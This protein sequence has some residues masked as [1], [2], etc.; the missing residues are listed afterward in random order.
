MSKT[1]VVNIYSDDY[2]IYIGR[3][4]SGDKH[5]LNTEPFEKGWLGNPFTL[6]EY[7][8]EK[9]IKKFKNAFVKKLKNDKEFRQ[10]VKKIKG[11]TLGCF[12]KPK[13]CHG[14]VIAG[15]LNNLLGES[16]E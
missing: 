12:C 4:G 11:K 3:G 13:S 9:S 8:R 14:D 16:D 2:D 15:Y 10:A 6:S 7:S 1:E 5:I